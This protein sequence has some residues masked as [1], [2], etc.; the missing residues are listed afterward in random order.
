MRELFESALG[1]IGGILG[2]VFVIFINVL[3]WIIGAYIFK[4]ILLS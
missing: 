3:P 1:F 4:W 2:I